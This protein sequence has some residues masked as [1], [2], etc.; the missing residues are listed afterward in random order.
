MSI[1]RRYAYRDHEILVSAMPIADR[2]GWR[3]E[4]CVITPD[5]EWHL[6]PT[7]DAVVL[8]DP[9]RCIELGRLR[10]ERVIEGLCIDAAG[11]S[12]PRVLH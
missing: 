3:P 9:A 7:H 12:F 11:E 8:V 10:A 6:V 4:I 2:S 5:S 1:N